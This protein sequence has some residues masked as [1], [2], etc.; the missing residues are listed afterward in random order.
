MG[1]ARAI[2]DARFKKSVEGNSDMLSSFV[3]HDLTKDEVFTGVM[4]QLI[5]GSDTTACRCGM[6]FR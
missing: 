1:T 4:L 2:I 3:R 6:F 5:A